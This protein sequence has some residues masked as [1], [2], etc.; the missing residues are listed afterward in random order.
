MATSIHHIGVPGRGR[1][2]GRGTSRHAPRR[3]P[4]DRACDRARASD[5]DGN[6][7]AAVPMEVAP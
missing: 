1:D 3:Q 5:P 6:D 4:G 7:I 2:A